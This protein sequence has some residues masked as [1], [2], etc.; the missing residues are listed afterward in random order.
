MHIMDFQ[1]L[2]NEVFN[3]G[4]QVMISLELDILYL[5]LILVF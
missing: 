3:F 4:N 2:Q 1:K 5:K